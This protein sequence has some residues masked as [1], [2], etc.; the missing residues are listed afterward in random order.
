MNFKVNV[1]VELNKAR[2]ELT[3]EQYGEVKQFIET[4]LLGKVAGWNTDRRTNNH[5][6][7]HRR[8]SKSILGRRPWTREEE[9]NLME[10]DRTFTGRRQSELWKLA[11]RQLGRTPHAI[12]LR[13]FGLRRERRGT[14]T[15][16]RNEISERRIHVDHPSENHPS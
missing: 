2:V 15:T 1:G 3:S 11:A 8:P 9:N 10:I 13:L 14:T 6:T 16:P 12:S 7:N 4:M 5:E